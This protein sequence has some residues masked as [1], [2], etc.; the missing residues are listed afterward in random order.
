MRDDIERYWRELA[1]VTRSMPFGAVARAA[2]ALLE[3]YRRGGTIFAIGNG[4]SAATASHFACDLAKN[5]RAEGLPAFRVMALT[6]N[7]PLVTA[8]AND[9]S[10]ARVFAEQLA[11]LV[12]PGDVVVAIS[13]SG[14]SPNVLLAAE[15]AHEL[16]AHVVAL[17]GRTGGK[18]ARLSD[19]TIRV[20]SDSIEQVEDAH[21]AITHSVCVVL[22]ARLRAEASEQ[23]LLEQA[24][25]A[26][27]AVPLETV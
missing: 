20:P 1:D 10:Y 4:G 25:G 23:V 17:T 18:L 27:V 19:Y 3:C 13:C 5:V 15:A 22:R 21:M 8:W 26:P 9:T 6:D 11:A 7:M 16:G 24:V 2:E 12:R 14:T